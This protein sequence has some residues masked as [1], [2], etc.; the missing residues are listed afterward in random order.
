MWRKKVGN[1]IHRRVYRGHEMK[2][3]NPSGK[4]FEKE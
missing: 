4:M 1:Q 2:I 3:V